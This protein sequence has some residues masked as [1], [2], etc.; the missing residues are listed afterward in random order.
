[1]RTRVFAVVLFCTAALL[2]SSPAVAQ[3]GARMSDPATGEN[4]HVEVGGYFWHPNPD[5]AITSESLGIIGSRID[6]VED[7][8]I[9]QKRFSQL[10]VVLRPGTKHKFRFEYTPINYDTVSA[11]R[12]NIVFNGITFPA[13]IPVETELKWNA[14][15]FGYEW[16][17]LYRE[18]GF[19][20]LLLEAK[21]TDVEATLSNVLDTE[22]VHA[23]APIPAIG[24]IGRVYVVPNIS[25][26]GEFSAFKLPD[27]GGDDAS[28]E[29]YGG[30]YFDLDIYGTVNF[31]DHFG[32]QLGYR[33]FDVFYKVD[34][35]E[36][37]LLLKGIY[38][39]GV[40]RF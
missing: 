3:F 11:L 23:R 10:K 19:L 22:F 2:T 9:E 20:G 30:R 12:R 40:L 33:S 35:D 21:Y 16:D 36:G 24:V 15:R 32:A 31:T 14:Y 25:V 34:D 17:F 27:I 5:I 29:E 6:F 28:S 1:M 39:G 7:L 8:G 18:R 38:F 13:V 4:Y 26:T 37:E